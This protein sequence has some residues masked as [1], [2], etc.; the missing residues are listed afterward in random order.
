MNPALPARRSLGPVP[1]FT[2]P[3]TPG[4]GS[5]N[6][7]IFNKR[8]KHSGFLGTFGD[9]VSRLEHDTGTKVTLHG[10]HTLSLRMESISG[11][12][13]SYRDEQYYG[14]GNNGVYND[15]DLDID[16]TFLK[17][18]H[19]QTHLSNSPFRNPNDDRVKLDY[20][21]KKMRF[22]WGDISAG[23]QGNSLIDF[24]RYLHG[25]QMSNNWTPRLRTTL[26]VSQ[27]KAETRSIVIPGN[28]SAGPY[29][30]YA[31]QIVP[32]SERV[33][34]DSRELVEG[35]DKDFTMD[36][37][38]GELRFT[39]GNVVL[40]SSTIAVSYETLGFGQSQGNIIGGRTEYSP[41]AGLN[42]GMTYV[43]QRSRGATG[44]I[45]RTEELRGF[46][47]PNFYPTDAPIDLTKPLIIKVGGRQLS[48]NEYTVDTSFAYTNRVFIKEAVPRDT[49]V[50]IQYVPYNNNP[51]PG[52][53][54][55]LG[56]DSRILLGKLGSLNLEA[57]LS[58]LNL[59]GS[60]I[61]GHAWQ[62][63]ADL[64]PMRNLHTN[65]TLRNVNP[66][67]SS[68][69]SPGFNRNEKSIEFTSDY[70]AT[71]R[72]HF[73]LNWQKALRPSYTGS[74]FTIAS[75]GN[76]NYNEYG[77]GLTY[78]LASNA[79]LNFSHNNLST[80]FALG[81]NS[82]NISDALGLNYGLR[83]LNFDLSLSRTLSDITS[84]A[85][86]LGLSGALP[87]TTTGTSSASQIYNSNT[88]TFSKRFGIHWQPKSWLNL[89]GSLSDNAITNLNAGAASNSNARDTQFDISFTRIRNVGIHYSFDLSDTGN[90]SFTPVTTTTTTGATGTTGSTSAAGSATG[91]GSGVAAGSGGVQLNPGR[92]A[93][94][95]FA[96]RILT[97]DLV[98][99]GAAAAQN[100]LNSSTS[101][102]GSAFG[103]LGGGGA[104]GSLG[105]L[106]TYSGYQGN[107]FVNGYGASSFGGR[108]AS[109]RLSIDWRPRQALTFGI[110]LDHAASI[111][112]YQFNNTRNNISTTFDWQLSRR[113]H[114]NA[115]YALQ[116]LA[117]NG[118]VGGTDSNSMILRLEGR[119]FGG[120]LGMIFGWTSMRTNSAFNFN[121]ASLLGNT[122]AAATGTT[123]TATTGA[124][125]A[126]T[127]PL[128]DTS[129]NL[130]SL[131]F[132]LEY[133]ISSRQT[134]FFEMLGSNSSGYLSNREDDYRFGLDY[135]LTR[136]LKFSLGWQ[137]LSHNYN[138]AQNTPLN[139]H[140]SS[141]LAEF[142]FN[143]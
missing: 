87:V 91:S 112:D 126:T 137:I 21:T 19:Y 141:L 43:T 125:S 90:S 89:G 99:G 69:Q 28:D 35:A 78:K 56:F 97:R 25:A 104:N 40:H 12:D 73:N 46:D 95:A 2:L 58:G 52:N 142:G 16:A 23:F 77:A 114:V 37:Y 100:A 60:N 83:N 84:T 57:A 96:S 133:P 106:G 86:L 94:A 92:S 17:Y 22:E 131:N 29:F 81:G 14:R 88:S 132:R 138:D 55:V 63:H 15:S 105:S 8:S 20:K 59:T 4:N 1:G 33:R 124:T 27:T 75:N 118:T 80:L 93:F 26:L 134:L 70:A 31:G 61:S 115:L 79:S 136:T 103:T 113:L 98:A 128:T 3:T 54:S 127:T 102:F 38:T 62:A 49:I 41:K 139:Y 109:H 130:S 65:L 111:G 11:N 120:K 36:P 47:Q 119:P 7:A 51:T 122:G 110:A 67:F 50:Q 117:Y 76:D 116:K 108:N 140:V 6:D 85:G 42:F 135:A 24:N 30:V 10:H 53:R 45:L 121:N 64:N 32:G 82:K 68:I 66:T 48:P 107:S 18:F 123:S 34:V 9:A 129:T 5:E 72:L 101:G 44:P 71:K 13:A 39:H 143:F 74:Q